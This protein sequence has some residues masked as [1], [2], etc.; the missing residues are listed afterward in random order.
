MPVNTNE[1]AEMF[2]DKTSQ[3]SHDAF[4][5]FFFN[6]LEFKTMPQ[7]LEFQKAIKFHRP[8][9]ASLIVRASTPEQ[10]HTFSND[11]TYCDLKWK[12]LL[13]RAW[14]VNSS[15]I[16]RCSHHFK[17]LMEQNRYIRIAMMDFGIL[18]LVVMKRRALQSRIGL[19]K[20]CWDMFWLRSG[21]RPASKIN[22]QIRVPYIFRH[23]NC[24]V[25][26]E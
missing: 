11:L 12:I 20:I 13:K 18:D 15:R 25:H 23:C 17:K 19:E 10:C 8:E 24:F 16:L 14:C 5:P 22:L 1:S 26:C 3:F 21:Q 4:T 2:F 7:F 6:G 9:N